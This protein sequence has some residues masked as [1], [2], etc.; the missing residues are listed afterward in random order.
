MVAESTRPP[1]PSSAR[2]PLQ[3][4]LSG[5]T[6]KGS[7]ILSGRA[8]EEAG[9]E[10]RMRSPSSPPL[11]GS[12]TEYRPTCLPRTSPRTCL[13]PSCFRS[14]PRPPYLTSGSAISSCLFR[15]PLPGLLEAWEPWRTRIE[16]LPNHCQPFDPVPCPPLVPTRPTSPNLL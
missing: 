11:C 14:V 5:Q 16:L 9:L 3:R 8:V 10:G 13:L 1:S 15:I 12:R 4:R 7:G 2:Q 6:R